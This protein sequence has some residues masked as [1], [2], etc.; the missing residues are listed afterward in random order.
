MFN[1]IQEMAGQARHDGSFIHLSSKK[2]RT[3]IKQ[4]DIP[5]L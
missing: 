4:Q 2:I 3:L 1:G 5:D